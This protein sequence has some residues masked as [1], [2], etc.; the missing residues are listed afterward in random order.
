MIQNE[1][2]SMVINLLC[3]F[4]QD[5]TFKV[6]DTSLLPEMDSLSFI[7]LVVNIETEFDIELYDEELIYDSNMTAQKWINIVKKHLDLSRIKD[8][9]TDNYLMMG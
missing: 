4:F 7:E 5:S 1:I 9:N 3:D 8:M 2:D 6:D